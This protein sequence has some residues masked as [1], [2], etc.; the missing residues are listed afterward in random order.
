MRFTL[1]KIC[2]STAIYWFEKLLRTKCK[3]TK[4]I[5]IFGKKIVNYHAF[6]KF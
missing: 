5:V 2:L 4:Y 6:F 1:S 3:I